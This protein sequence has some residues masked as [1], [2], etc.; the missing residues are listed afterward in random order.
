MSV[1]RASPDGRRHR[2]AGVVAAI[3]TY[4]AAFYFA[5]VATFI[6]FVSS[7]YRPNGPY[8]TMDCQDPHVIFGQICRDW[9]ERGLT[10]GSRLGFGAAFLAS[11][12]LLVL[13]ARRAAW[14]LLLVP[15]A[16]LPFFA[17]EH[18]V[19]LGT[20]LV[21]WIA[22][23]SIT[24]LRLLADGRSVSGIRWLPV[25]LLTLGA[26][27][28]MVLSLLTSGPPVVTENVAQGLKSWPSIE[29]YDMACPAPNECEVVGD[30][31]H[32]SGG[33]V[34]SSRAYV[35]QQTDGT[36]SQPTRIGTPQTSSLGLIACARVGTC[37]ATAMDD[38]S[39]LLAEVDGRWSGNHEVKIPH[40]YAPLQS[41][42]V[43]CSPDGTCWIV[44][45][46]VLIGKHHSYSRQYAIGEKDGHWLAPYPLGGARL[47]IR[48]RPIEGVFF[49]AMSCW[50]TSSCTFAITAFGVPYLSTVL[51]TEVDGRWGPPTS[52]AG[53]TVRSTSPERPFVKSLTCTS[54]GNC[55][56]GGY[57]INSEGEVGF[58]QQEI[59]GRWRPRVKDIGVSAPYLE[60]QVVHVAC[61]KSML[62][63]ATGTSLL[64]AGGGEV[65]FVQT[66]LSGRWQRPVLMKRLSHAN[67]GAWI[68]GA[69]C[70]TASTCDVAGQ[71]GNSTQ[72]GSF[73]AAYA[74]SRWSYWVLGLNGESLGDVSSLTCSGKACWL[75]GN[76]YS[77][78]LIPTA[79]IFPFTALQT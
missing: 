5:Y 1:D 63:V 9:T 34:T 53:T 36:W 60:S 37:I 74:A 51:Q 38:A 32:T 40:L 26:V 15:V 43:A 8:G 7:P 67:G 17:S 35:L 79:L 18:A 62:C 11:F 29:L 44:G 69:A 19:W 57:E 31:P 68:I 54:S 73:E 2:W 20:V 16:T 10:P 48:G 72:Q 61:Y 56:L 22:V 25:G 39:A 46:A 21:S 41:N 28:A 6:Y 58:V 70:P 64:P 27:G 47:R 24:G 30:L 75:V 76:L 12:L 14:V 42:A 33:N 45:F 71:Y 77:K 13:L 52:L 23:A 49:S 59:D 50:S 55:L 78:A 4:A 66:E 3:L 65:G